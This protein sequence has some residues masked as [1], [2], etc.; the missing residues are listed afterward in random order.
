MFVKHLC[1]PKR[2]VLQGEFEESSILQL[3]FASVQIRFF[4]PHHTVKGHRSVKKRES[5]VSVIRTINREL[6]FLR[7]LSHG[8]AP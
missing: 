7:C 5:F 8:D 1:L 3:A 6:H 2:G 4:S